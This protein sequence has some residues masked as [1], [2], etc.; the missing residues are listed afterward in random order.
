M[1]VILLQGISGDFD[2]DARGLIVAYPNCQ[3]KTG[4][5]RAGKPSFYVVFY[6]EVAS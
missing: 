1:S 5:L 4:G 3:I 2:T 6:L